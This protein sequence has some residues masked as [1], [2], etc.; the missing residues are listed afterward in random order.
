[1]Y[2]RKPTEQR[3]APRRVCM[4]VTSRLSWSCPAAAADSV[5]VQ[6]LVERDALTAAGDHLDST[7]DRI[8]PEQ[9]VAGARELPSLDRFAVGRGDFRA[10]GDVQACFDDA[11]VAQ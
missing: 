5:G 9:Q 11:V 8:A 6:V 2:C 4:S 1:M 3:C 7:G 10:G